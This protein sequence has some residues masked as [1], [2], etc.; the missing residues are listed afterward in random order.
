MPDGRRAASASGGVSGEEWGG[1]ADEFIGDLSRHAGGRPADTSQREV[2]GLCDEN[3][4]RF[5][6]PRR[7]RRFGGPAR[8]PTPVM[9]RSRPPSGYSF[10]WGRSARRRPARL[11]RRKVEM[12]SKTVADGRSTAPVHHRPSRHYRKPTCRSI[13]PGREEADATRFAGLAIGD[14]S[15]RGEEKAR[16]CKR[17]VDRWRFGAVAEAGS[18]TPGGRWRT[19]HPSPLTGAGPAIPAASARAN[20]FAH[21]ACGRRDFS[22][23]RKHRPKHPET[24]FPQ[25]ATRLF[26][27]PIRAL[28]SRPD[29][30]AG[31]A[32]PRSRPDRSQGSM[33]RP[34]A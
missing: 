25:T 12:P 13:V 31:L 7:P 23:D 14:A 18:N 21:G 11:H 19:R 20:R 33:S 17:K 8:R 15:G 29:L 2:N 34:P 10:T 5:P 6:G 24:L 32:R 9:P 26:A 30:V 16:I 27:P 22:T 1:G 28:P 3:M 4:P